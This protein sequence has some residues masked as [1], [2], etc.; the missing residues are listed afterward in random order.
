[1]YVDLLAKAIPTAIA[2]STITALQFGRAWTMRT[3]P[4][5]H[6]LRGP[7][8]F[9]TSSRCAVHECPH[10][11]HNCV[12]SL[13]ALRRAAGPSAADSSTAS[14]AIVAPTKAPSGTAHATICAADNS[15]LDSQLQPVRGRA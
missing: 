9:T 11:L 2:S 1:M 3:V 6:V 5:L 15:T 12:P 4:D 13:F 14:D 7:D 10:S 8:A